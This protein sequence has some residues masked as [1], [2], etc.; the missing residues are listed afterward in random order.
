MRSIMVIGAGALACA[1]AG[2]QV[3]DF[4]TL[5]D[6]TAPTDNMTL[7]INLP[8]VV[9][10]PFGPIEVRFG[11]DT[12]GDLVRDNPLRFEATGPDA[13]DGFSNFL[14]GLND[15]ADP[16][17]ETLLG[18]WATRSSGNV[19]GQ[20]I[21]IDYSEPVFG[22]SGEIWD[23]E[24]RGDSEEFEQWLVEAFDASGTL[25]AST[26]SPAGIDDLEPLDGEPWVFALAAEG[27]VRL[28]M[29]FVGNASFA[30][31]AFN[32]FS[33]TSSVDG[34]TLL[35]HQPDA[36]NNNAAGLEEA[37]LYWS[38][39]VTIAATDLVVLDMAG[40]GLG[41]PVQVSGSGTQVTTVTFTGAPGGADTG[42]P[43]PL[44]E[45]TYAIT[46][47]DSARAT[48]NNRPID[49]DGDGVAGG[50]VTV[51]VINDCFADCDGNGALNVDDID[52]FVAS[53]LSGCL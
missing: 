28:R 32:N 40:A 49:G 31:I 25:L 26:M 16:G 47:L 18:S 7:D 13:T 6:G 14:L 1:S 19:V 51:N 39:P 4:E 53:F 37:C 17:F 43:V 33:A 10:G 34:P 20:P 15:T 41:V 27:I 46:V 38:E 21:I 11:G 45:G 8:Y 36:P 48:A 50:S 12:D 3:I 30:G 23:I 35:T 29:S 5:P 2:A 44:M 52:C 22:V 9:A 24:G 42:A